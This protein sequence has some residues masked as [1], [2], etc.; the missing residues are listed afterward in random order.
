MVELRVPYTVRTLQYHF[1][2]E[3]VIKIV[4]LDRTFCM[5]LCQYGDGLGGF[6]VSSLEVLKIVHVPVLEYHEYKY[7]PTPV[8]STHYSYRTRYGVLRI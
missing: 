7:C 1:T 3:T 6:N 2:A 5:A 8:V 4:S